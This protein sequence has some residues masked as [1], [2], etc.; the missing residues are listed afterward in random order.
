MEC[1]IV[2]LAAGASS[3]MGRSKQLLM[4][5][6]RTLLEHAISSAKKS[7]AKGIVLVVGANEEAISQAV[8]SPGITI[9]KNETWEQG[10]STSIIAGL[11]RLLTEQPTLESVIFMACDQP[12]VTA[13]L[14]N[15]LIDN[16]E[17]IQKPIVA[18]SYGNSAGIPALFDKTIFASLMTLTG[19][20]GAKKIINQ[21]PGL[22]HT[23]EFPLGNNDIDTLSDYE[24]LLKQT[25]GE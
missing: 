18:S 8:N 1:G 10:M 12:F 6:G 14:L 25:T 16:Y 5:Q 19:D 15:K 23:I 9:V 21:H 11:Q 17:R 7:K 22:V 3:R 13:D 24:Q 2:L 20:K 4:Y